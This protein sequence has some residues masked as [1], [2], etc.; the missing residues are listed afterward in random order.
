MDYFD[1]LENQ[2]NQQVF[3]TIGSG[4]SANELSWQI[5]SKPKGAKFIY[6][7]VLGAGGGGGGGTS[8]VGANNAGGGG[9]GSG[10][11]VCAIAPANLIPDTL[12]VSVGLGGRGG[13]PNGNGLEGGISYISTQPNLEFSNV[14]LAS[15]S[16]ASSTAKGGTPS[17]GVGTGAGGFDGTGIGSALGAHLTMYNSQVGQ[18]G[19]SGYL[20]PIII[21]LNYTGGAGGGSTASATTS[22]T[23]GGSVSEL[24]FVP[25]VKGGDV[26]Q[27]GS[28]GFLSWLPDQVVSNRLP[29]MSTGGAGGGGNFSGTGGNGGRGQFGSGGGGGGAGTVGGRGGDGG[30]GIIIIQTW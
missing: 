17:A 4:A 1:L 20:N 6:M 10:A 18:N 21:Q 24:G 30:N 8:A 25:M 15:T 26:G 28:N 7:F 3:Y 16:T 9:G 29:F 5:W 14:I 2:V 11:I 12:Y 23:S 27:D 19:N 13:E 22:S